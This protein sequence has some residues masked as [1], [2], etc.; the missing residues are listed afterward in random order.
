MKRTMMS[1]ILL[2]LSFG[3][4]MY[5]VAEEMQEGQSCSLS[6]YMP[7]GNE[8]G[9]AA[10]RKTYPQV[11]IK[12]VEHLTKEDIFTLVL[13]QSSDVDLFGSNTYNQPSYRE[14]ITRNFYMPIESVKLKGFAESCYPGVRE[15]LFVEDQLVGIPVWCLQ[16]YQF[17]VEKSMWQ[18]LG[19]EDEMLPKTWIELFDFIQNQWPALSVDHPD[20][21]AIHAE[22][23]WLLFYELLDDYSVYRRQLSVDP[24]YDTDVFRDTLS[25][26]LSIHPEE[27]M[28][29]DDEKKAL[30]SAE[31]QISPVAPDLYSETHYDYAAIAFTDDVNAE[32]FITLGLMVI[33]PYSENRELCEAY[34]ECL[35]DNMDP[36]DRAILQS[37]YSTPVLTD[38]W[39]EF[40]AEYKATIEKYST[41]IA[42]TNDAATKQALQLEMDTYAEQCSD[43][44]SNQW[45]ISRESLEKYR[46]TVKDQVVMWDDALNDREVELFQELCNH[47]YDRA[48]PVEA[49]VNQLNRLYYFRALEDS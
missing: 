23:Y 7:M 11:E 39:E 3:I 19:M 49:I 9:N 29:D 47:V 45:L 16:A 2:I 6:V 36:V 43:V 22:D 31:L 12:S 15:V 32:A 21:C 38:G 8:S 13:T 26:Y 33:N 24:G 4:A 30:F 42:Q 34:L 5:S 48:I 27:Q 46:Q 20:W 41:Q 35:V 40:S 17:G 10:F 1:I 25:A 28:I 18:E 37:D 14:L 44:L